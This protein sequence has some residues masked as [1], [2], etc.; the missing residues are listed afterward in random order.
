MIT[1]ST[2]PKSLGNLYI[3]YNLDLL[4]KKIK[5]LP[6]NIIL[7]RYVD[8]LNL[9]SR[10]LEVLLENFS[11]IPSL[12]ELVQASILVILSYLWIPE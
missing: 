9:F 2:L 3:L 6:N 11:N 1:I 12:R 10:H 5:I 8:K 7:L 4:G